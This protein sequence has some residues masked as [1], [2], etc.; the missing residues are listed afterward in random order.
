[1]DATD[2]EEYLA[3]ATGSERLIQRGEIAGQTNLVRTEADRITLLTQPG[4]V[5]SNESELIRSIVSLI[6]EAAHLRCLSLLVNTTPR[7]PAWERPG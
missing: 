6:Q 7:Y 2:L 5:R 3:L 1:M 4:S